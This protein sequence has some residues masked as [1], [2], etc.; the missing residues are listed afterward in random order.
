MVS[1][2]AVSL[3]AWAGPPRFVAVDE[4][5]GTGD[6]VPGF[7]NGV[8]F[9]EFPPGEV[10]PDGETILLA[11]RMKLGGVNNSND[12]AMWLVDDEFTMVMREN[13]SV[14]GFPLGIVYDEPETKRL[15]ND[16]VVLFGAEI[17]GAGI[18]SDNDDCL[19]IYQDGELTLLARD[20][21]Q[22]P[23]GLPGERFEAIHWQQL[24]VADGGLTVFSTNLEDLEGDY[25]NA[26]FYYD[27]NAVTTI[28][29]PGL[30]VPGTPG[31]VFGES[32]AGAS[33][34]AS[35][36]VVARARVD[37][38]ADDEINAFEY[39][40][41][42]G[43]AHALQ[44]VAHVGQ[45]A[46]GLEGVV[47][48]VDILPERALSADGSI[49][50]IGEVMVD[51]ETFVDVVWAGSPNALE[52]VAKTGDAF[53]PIEGATFRFFDEPW[54][55]DAGM[56]MLVAWLEGEGIDDSNSQ[57]ACL[58][59][60]GVWSVVVREGDEVPGLPDALITNINEFALNDAMQTFVSVT[61]DNDKAA[62]LAGTPGQMGLVGAELT[63]IG[64]GDQ[65]CRLLHSL[66][67]RSATLG[68]NGRLL[69]TAWWGG[70]EE[71]SVESYATP[72]CAA[73]CNADGH[74][75]VLDYV[76]QQI[77]FVNGDMQADCDC[78]GTLTILDFVCFQ[79][80]FGQG[81]D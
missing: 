17:D 18:T 29:R 4:V 35:G 74:I 24:D 72:L 10:S 78:D 44:V 2:V 75:N 7:P 39:A 76:C 77:L 51:D 19:W 26:L 40:I 30:L 41:L 12:Y 36:Q 54:I 1:I 38:I 58:L 32:G 27:G 33:V 66:F 53:E 5:Y 52:V 13:A 20:E 42:A 22:I 28:V 21:M 8:I 73:D 31:A 25:P 81:C 80:L 61:M 15:A 79:G 47:T 45:P 63:V 70:T 71:S 11:A 65:K 34:N 49:A 64:A 6:L 23:D 68:A 14:P 62:L 59:N 55:N 48:D 43:E 3:M 69:Q 67:N 16:G 57:V 37:A 9:D 46:P 50:F 56:L 60:D